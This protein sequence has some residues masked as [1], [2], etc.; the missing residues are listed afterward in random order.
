MLY[1]FGLALAQLG[2]TILLLGHSSVRVT[3]SIWNVGFCVT[4]I[5]ALVLLFFVPKVYRALLWRRRKSQRPSRE[6]KA[7]RRRIAAAIHDELGS[8]LVCAISL[9][10][11]N[12]DAVLLQ[13]LEQCLLDMHTVVDSMDDDADV[14]QVSMSR[15]RHRLQP[16]L[17]RRGIT[18]H[19]KICAEDEYAKE[20]KK[21]FEGFKVR[22]C[23]AVLKEAVSN[24]LRH[25]NATEIWITLRPVA[26]TAYHANPFIV[27]SVEDNGVGVAPEHLTDICTVGYGAGLQNMQQHACEIGGTLS[28]RRREGGG[29]V[30]QLCWSV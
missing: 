14:L 21:C 6:V 2:V 26:D 19:W 3:P 20:N 15:F 30:L 7:E 8:Q 11:E 1:I 17:D 28:V 29:T 4:S 9:A 25:A 5:S 16:V 18:L 22:L 23:M 24:A 27:L 10:R 12:Q 13:T